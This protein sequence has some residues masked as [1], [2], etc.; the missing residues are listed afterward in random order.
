MQDFNLYWSIFILSYCDFCLSKISEYFF[1]LDLKEQNPDESRSD[2]QM[3]RG[4][5]V[6]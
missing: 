4:D 1:T 5:N 3:K 2:D 6:I